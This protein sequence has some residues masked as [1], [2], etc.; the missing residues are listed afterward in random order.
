ML[1]YKHKVPCQNHLLLWMD[2]TPPCR[3]FSS[4]ACNPMNKDFCI[5]IYQ[6]IF[7]KNL[8][9]R[10]LLINEFKFLIHKEFSNC[11][12]I[13]SCRLPCVITG[14]ENTICPS[15]V[16]FLVFAENVFFLGEPQLPK[17]SCDGPF[18]INILSTQNWGKG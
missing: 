8:R 7:F 15:F 1:L 17:I 9:K 13:I 3:Q 11:M 14:I 16:K 4:I 6:T 12:S 10:S 5:F 2:I 18:G